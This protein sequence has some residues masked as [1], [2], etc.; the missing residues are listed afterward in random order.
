[1]VAHTPISIEELEKSFCA[2]HGKAMF[3][4]WWRSVH[5]RL[6]NLVHRRRTDFARAAHWHSGHFMP[7]IPS[8]AMHCIGQTTISTTG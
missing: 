4:M 1:M 5:K 8:N 2:W 7:C 3:Q 6:H